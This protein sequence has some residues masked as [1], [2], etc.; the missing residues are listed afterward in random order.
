MKIIILSIEHLNFVVEDIPAQNA[1]SPQS[2][3]MSLS[4][5]AKVEAI[6]QTNASS[7]ITSPIDAESNPLGHLTS[8]VKFINNNTVEPQE[9]YFLCEAANFLGILKKGNLEL[10]EYMIRRFNKTG[11]MMTPEATCNFVEGNHSILNINRRQ[12][13][14]TEASKLQP[15]APAR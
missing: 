4:A 11:R 1:F 10:W 3:F 13:K 14:R 2:F 15:S 8:K 12:E 9:P 6:V 7:G 5:L